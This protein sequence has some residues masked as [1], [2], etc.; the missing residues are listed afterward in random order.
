MF[1]I[2]G[3]KPQLLKKGMPWVL[4]PFPP[5][6]PLSDPARAHRFAEP[7]RS[8][9]N[10]V[11][12][13]AVRPEGAGARGCPCGAQSLCACPHPTRRHPE[14]MHEALAHLR[15]AQGTCRPRKDSQ[16]SWP[17]ARTPRHTSALVPMCTNAA[18]GVRV[19]TRAVTCVGRPIAW[20][21]E[22][23]EPHPSPR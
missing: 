3:G 8:W 16:A 10:G 23:R 14:T 6:Q 13:A 11:L 17:P 7:P 18:H 19:S 12:Q 15:P 9:Q 4:G 1:L 2:G 21:G 5:T 20:V 22:R